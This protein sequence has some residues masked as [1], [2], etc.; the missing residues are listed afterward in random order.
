MRKIAIIAM[1]FVLITS[2]ATIEGVNGQSADMRP[3]IVIIM[4]DDLGYGG[5]SSY[6]NTFVQ[7][8]NIDLL[9]ANGVK[10]TDFHSN[11]S[12]CSPTRAAL[13]TGK[14][15]QSTG[16]SGVITARSHRDVG[17]PLNETTIAEE[18]KKHGYNTG[19]FGKWHLGYSKEYNPTRQGFDT[20]EGF[21]SGNIDYHAH[22]D[23]A[24][25]LDWWQGDE[26]QNNEG[27]TTDLITSNAVAYIKANTPTTTGKPFFLYLPHEA[28]HSPYQRRIDKALR[29]IGRRGTK[30]VDRDQIRS[31]YKE[32]VEVMDDGVGTVM[33]A[34]KDTGQHDNTIVL[35]LSDNG[36]NRYGS[37]G[38]LR[39]HKGSVYEGGSRVPAIISFPDKIEKGTVS[40]QTVLTMDILPTLLDFIG[41]KPSSSDID[42]TSVKENLLRQ[43]P[44]PRRDVFYAFKNKRFIRSGNWKLVQI[45]DDS[46]NSVELF[47]LSNDLG[48]KNDVSSSHTDLKNS[49]LQKLNRWTNNVSE[50]VQPISD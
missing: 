50:G 36:A 34:I 44:L 28:P 20:F 25:N 19:M 6:G 43:T 18:F 15:Q 10:F 30:D 32:M 26:I 46:D 1:S 41:Q 16:V 14:Y 22:I 3:N 13:M 48:E 4:A 40:N 38:D 11:G 42:G 12:V 37:N 47:N 8:P 27:Y 9:A 49:L 21:V 39:G 29:D 45:D 23:V 33:Q 24:G 31:I 7:T 17:L 5:L 35:F 2:C